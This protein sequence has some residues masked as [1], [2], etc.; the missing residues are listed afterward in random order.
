L[1][2]LINDVALSVFPLLNEGFLIHFTILMGLFWIIIGERVRNTRMRML[3]R[4]H[5]LQKRKGNPVLPLLDSSL[6]DCGS[7]R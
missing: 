2:E 4:N 3:S 6:S 5:M 7:V 1:T